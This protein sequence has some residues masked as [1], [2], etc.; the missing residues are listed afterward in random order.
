MHIGEGVLSDRQ[1]LNESK[2]R[3]DVILRRINVWPMLVTEMVL[4]KKSP[5]QCLDIVAA[6]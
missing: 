1:I 3:A 6:F 2:K 5:N 4:D